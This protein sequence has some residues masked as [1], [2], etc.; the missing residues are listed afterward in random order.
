MVYA[1]VFGMR[2]FDTGIRTINSTIGD[3][4]HY[5][6]ISLLLLAGLALMAMITI[7]AIGFARFVRTLTVK[8]Q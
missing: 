8:P 5:A 4:F 3:I 2:D 7:I 1:F 6:A